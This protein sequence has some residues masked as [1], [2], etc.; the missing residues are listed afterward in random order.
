MDNFRRPPGGQSPQPVRQPLQLSNVV[1]PLVPQASVPC[2]NLTPAYVSVAVPPPRPQS[3][4]EDRPVVPR[5][6]D[7]YQIPR[8]L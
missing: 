3:V 4:V 1:P 8:V 5:P 7:N 2:A 6:V